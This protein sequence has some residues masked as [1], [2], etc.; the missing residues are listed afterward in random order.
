MRVVVALAGRK[1]S[2][3][4]TIARTLVERHGFSHASFGQYVRSE[5]QRR[6]LKLD[7]PGLEE[8]GSA[9]IQDLGWERFCREVLRNVLGASELVVDGVRHWEVVPILRSITSPAKV[10]LVFVEIDDDERVARLSKR[11][12]NAPERQDYEYDGM[13]QDLG[14]LRERADILVD[15]M[16]SDAAEEILTAIRSIET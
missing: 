15:G 6:K 14:T 2:G 4:S 12:A 8:L 11:Y 5:G 10:I 16:R 7:T 13:I 3:K 9:L 1:G